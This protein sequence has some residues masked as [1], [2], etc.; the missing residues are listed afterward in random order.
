MYA[1]IVTIL[2]IPQNSSRRPSARVTTR[3]GLVIA[4]WLEGRRDS[5]PVGGCSNRL[6]DTFTPTLCGFEPRRSN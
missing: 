3:G 4:S 1:A 5:F 6:R 2:G